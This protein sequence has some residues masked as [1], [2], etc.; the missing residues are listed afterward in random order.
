MGVQTL[1][2]RSHRTEILDDPRVPEHVRER[3]YR[4]L[5]K[6]HRWLGN[7]RAVI[8]LIGGD[9]LP[10]KKVLDVGC[11][12]GALLQDVRRTLGVEVVGVDLSPPQA[13]VNIPIYRRDALREDLP[14]ADIAVSVVVAHHFTS[15]ELRLL[16]C[17]V[18]R[19]CRRFIILDLVRHWLPFSFFRT[20]ASC[21]INPV[22]V[23]DGIRSIERAFT[24]K[25][26]ANITRESL[27]ECGGSFRQ[28]VAPFYIRQI[29]D[30]RY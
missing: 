20:F 1:K 17:N 14:L 25:E 4:D 19:S 9:P 26:F 12:H 21:L 22:N 3:C 30:I 15:D 10:V 2:E 18:G 29:L 11:G 13:K 24:P 7:H 6:T 28:T 16:I 5:A 23:E 8:R 27:L